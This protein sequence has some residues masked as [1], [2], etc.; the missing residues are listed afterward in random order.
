[1][2][3]LIFLLVV[4]SRFGVPL[5][6]PK[7]P[8]P[9]IVVALV[10]DAADQTIFAS[11]NVEPANYQGYDKALDIFYLTIAYLS[12]IRNWTDG[13]A[14]RVAQF[15]WYYRLIGVLA[16]EFTE[17]R[18]LL[19]IFP[20]TFEYFFIGYELIRVWW[21]PRRLSHR[22]VLTLAAAIWIFIKLPQ[23]TWIHILQLD[24]TDAL[25][26]HA[27]FGPSIIVVL[28]LAAIAGWMNRSKLPG[29]DWS[30]SFNVDAHPTTVRFVLADQP[31]A[32]FAL[33]KHPQFEKIGLISLVSI[34]F[35]LILPEY[36]GGPI[37]LAI[38]VGL[39][40]LVNSKAVGWLA[41]GGIQWRTIGVHF[42]S[43]LVLNI[44]IVVA[45]GVFL[46][47]T[48]PN[49]FNLGFFLVLISLLGTFYDR[50]RAERV[51]NSEL[52]DAVQ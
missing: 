42:V 7:F 36:D 29:V 27:W 48:G 16:F 20:N 22:N 9:A 39:V 49:R 6:I 2:G 25:D 17:I 51:P 28:A 31:G 37:S 3:N 18:A 52:A 40:V 13:F 14:F 23:E 44:G 43:M 1:M 21:N 10:I 19:L 33:L 12:T 30:A 45:A 11:F 38:G 46:P 50:Y 32:G 15:L 26:S 35:S 4:L 24:F 5:L 34:I 8:L 41:D 47:D